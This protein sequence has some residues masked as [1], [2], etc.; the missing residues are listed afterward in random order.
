MKNK[1]TIGSKVW[2][3]KAES[4][5]NFQIMERKVHENEKDRNRGM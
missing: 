5:K 3:Q 2:I 4:Y 1:F